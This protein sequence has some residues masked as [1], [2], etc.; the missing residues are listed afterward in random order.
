MPINPVS[1]LPTL[2]TPTATAIADSSATLGATVTSSG[3]F[4]ITDRGTCW[5]TGAKPTTNCASDGGLAVAAFTQGRGA[6]PA[7]TK[8]YYRGYA[9][10]SIGTGY[11]PDGSFYTEPATQASG[12]GFASLTGTSMTVNWTRGSGDGVIV[13]MKA[14]SAVD[15]D[16]VD[17]T[18]TTYT[19]NAA[20]TSGTQIGSGNYVIYKGA[21]NNVPVTGLTADTTYYVA[22]YEYAGAVDTSGVNQGTNYKLPPA[23]EYQTTPL[24][25]S[26]TIT[27]FRRLDR[28]GRGD[29]RH[30][31]VL[32]RRRRG[33]MRNFYFFER[34]RWRRWWGRSQVDSY[35]ANIPVSPGF[36]HHWRG[37]RW[38]ASTGDR[39]NG[40]ELLL[41]QYFD[42]SMQW[43]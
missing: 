15:A 19:A 17:G 35:T 7:Q 20:F 26:A 2:T 1:L 40:G 31:G 28:P 30:G 41:C 5:G 27:D 12:V 4:T 3:G 16:P 14:G 11:S 33:R 43:R 9:A 18:Y 29:V 13:L 22:V 36:L 10:N 38:L 23:T 37:W 8:I 6:L 42:V 21:A 34:G 25:S 39:R 32:G 24:A